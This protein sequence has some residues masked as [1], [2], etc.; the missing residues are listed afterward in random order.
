M[1]VVKST[2]IYIQ[3]LVV[4]V[5]NKLHILFISLTVYNKYITKRNNTEYHRLCGLFDAYQEHVS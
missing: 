1:Y 5:A 3:F 2:I 4:H